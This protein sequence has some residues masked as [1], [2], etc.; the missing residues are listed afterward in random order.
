MGQAAAKED[1]TITAVERHKVLKTDGTVE[2]MTFAFNGKL[3]HGLSE[4]VKIMGKK[5]ATVGSTAVN[6]PVHIVAQGGKFLVEPSNEGRI[7]QG[8]S[9][10]FFNSKKAARDRDKAKTCDETLD[11]TGEGT[12]RVT[13]SPGCTVFIG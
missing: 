4:N 7:T 13:V 1:D 9:M 11:P 2:E 8:S 12:G 5:A 6:S 10:V 3:S